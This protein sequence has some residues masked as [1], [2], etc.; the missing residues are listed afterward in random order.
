[1]LETGTTKNHRREGL[2]KQVLIF[3][4]GIQ[5]GKQRNFQRFQLH[6][7]VKKISFLSNT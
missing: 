1:M 7:E 5:V 3:M 2:A 4:L 6:E